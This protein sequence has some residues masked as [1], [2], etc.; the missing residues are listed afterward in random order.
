MEALADDVA[1]GAFEA[2]DLFADNDFDIKAKV[3]ANGSATGTADFVFGAEFSS[4]WGADFVTLKCE[5]ESGIV[6]EDGTVILEGTSHE[7]DFA[8]GVVVFEE[9]TPFEI[10]VDP[11]GLFTLRWCELPTLALEIANGHL[12]VK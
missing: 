2:G 6:L 1:F 7:Q 10:V 8:G 3:R 12:K 11:A 5:I 4:L 9:F